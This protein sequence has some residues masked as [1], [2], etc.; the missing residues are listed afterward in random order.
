MINASTAFKTAL[1]N[2]QRNYI[3]RAEITLTDGTVLNLDNSNIWQNGFSMEDAV[4]SDNT[5]DV[6]AA[7]INKASLTILFVQPVDGVAKIADVV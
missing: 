7:I 3:E 6:G 2:D 5:F 1:A 4:S